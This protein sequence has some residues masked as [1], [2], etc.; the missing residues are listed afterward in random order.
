MSQ[1]LTDRYHSLVQTLVTLVEHRNPYNIDH[2]K[3]VAQY[4]DAIAQRA[5]LDEG[6]RQR[7]KTAAELHTLGVLLQI[8]EKRN[9]HSLPATMLGMC[10]GRENS[11]HKRE[12]EI[13]RNILGDVEGLD[14][15]LPVIVQRH[16][17]FD[18]QG[19]MLGLSGDRILPEARI[20]AVADAFVDLATPKSHRDPNTVSEVMRR[21]RRAAGTQFDPATVSTLETIVEEEEGLWGASARSRRFETSRCRHWLDLGYFYRQTGEPEW[22]LRCYVA[23]ARLARMLPDPALE[24][25]ATFG[26]F[27]VF[28]DQ[29]QFDRARE[30]LNHARKLV[31]G[32]DGVERRR[33]LMMWGTLEWLTGK[34]E[35]GEQ[36]LDGLAKQYATDLDVT[37]LA[38]TTA[39]QAG[40]ML[41]FRGLDDPGHLHWLERF[42]ELV[43]QHDLF[44][45]LTRFRPQTIPLLLSAHIHEIRPLLARNALTRM[46]EPCLE[47]LREEMSK[48]HPNDWAGRLMQHAVVPPGESTEVALLPATSPAAAG[49]TPAMEV[50]A[51]APAPVPAVVTEAVAAQALAP[52]A[53]SLKVLLLGRCRLEV[54]GRVFDEDDWPTQKSMKL[55]GFLAHRRGAVTADEFLMATFW[56]DSD[57]TRA[58]NSLR[59]AVH[60]IRGVLRDLLQNDS[61]MLERSRKSRTLALQIPYYLD[62]Q[63]LEEGVREATRLQQLKKESEALQVLKQVL[64]LYRGEFLEGASDEWAQGIRTHLSEVYLKALL[65]MARCHLSLGEAEAAELTSRRALRVDDLREDVHAALIEALTVQGR[66]GEALRHYQDTI[67]LYQKEIGVVPSSLHEIYDRL[68]AEFPVR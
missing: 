42:M 68:L 8:E 1:P 6:A 4:S 55:F 50:A 67:A 28:C 34:A 59:N 38:I 58:R 3:L 56:P 17:W 27:T 13:L 57:D 7:L 24:M 39:Y 35:N 29:R 49:A 40:M 14:E 46:G 25:N 32:Q 11:M 48:F 51:A 63:G 54:A 26:Q 10:S 62:V 9:R 2:C 37:G 30:T 15:C 21:L 20:L 41:W 65:A 22:S 12:E 52:E 66:R 18:G 64:G 16:E 23:A 53:P 36:I 60:Q 61:P 43:E 31:E 19:S 5:G 44:D 47:E 33:F 45:V